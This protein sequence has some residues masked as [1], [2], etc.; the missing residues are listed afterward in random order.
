MNRK[1]GLLVFL[2]ILLIAKIRMVQATDFGSHPDYIYYITGSGT[3]GEYDFYYGS[4]QHRD[5][6]DF[7]G[8]VIMKHHESDTMYRTIMIDEG[9]R[10]SVAFVGFFEEGSFGVAM[11]KF[12]FNYSVMAY[13]LQ[14]TEIMKYDIFGNYV[15]RVIFNETFKAF[16]NHGYLII[17]SKDAMY[18]SDIVLNSQLEEIQLNSERESTGD[19]SYQFQGTC[20]ING[21]SNDDIYLVE[22]GNYEIVINRLKYHFILHI[23]IKSDVQGIINEGIYIGK[24]TINAKGE[25]FLDDNTYLSG[26]E[27]NEV[28]YHTLRIIGVGELIED[29]YFTIEP[30]VSGIEDNGEYISGVYIDI[31][32]AIAYLN[33]TPYENNTLIARPGKYVLTI[34]GVN[35]YRSTLNFT[36]F[37]SVVNLENNGNYQAEYRLNFIGEGRLNGEIIQSG[38]VLN[39]GVYDFE[40]WFENTLFRQ[41]HFTVIENTD[42][43][44]HETLKIP[45]LEIILGI[46]S[47][48]GLFLVFR[49]K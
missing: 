15:D 42:E 30:H 45:F 41:Y 26:T 9:Y 24:T 49:K 11:V 1:I 33:M 12:D 14:S 17:L 43:I 37:P 8:L 10:E 35:E 47:L 31:P 18:Q 13:E 46:F 19:F 2:V 21:E 23:I 16:N 34:M 3:Y 22:P 7:N 29:Y 44:V 39:E 36:I 6:G 20:T 38:S 48:V 4:A 27:I 5:S 25:L 40:L 32:N 28:G